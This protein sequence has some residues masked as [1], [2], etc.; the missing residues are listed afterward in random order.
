VLCRRAVIR[1]RQ[2]VRGLIAILRQNGD[3]MGRYLQA[4]DRWSDAFYFSI[5]DEFEPTA[6]LDYPVAGRPIY[7]AR[8]SRSGDVTVMTPAGELYDIIVGGPGEYLNHNGLQLAFRD[9]RRPRAAGPSWSVGAPG[10][11]QAPA[12]LPSETRPVSPPS[13]YAP[14]NDPWL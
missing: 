7:R 4:P 1:R 5:R 11:W 3:V 9:M 12:S 10:S 6:R 2:D 14:P 8:R 13:R